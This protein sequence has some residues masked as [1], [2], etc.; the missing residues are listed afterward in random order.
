MDA[1][2]PPTEP[3]PRPL[4]FTTPSLFRAILVVGTVA[5]IAML[6]ARAA[7]PVM[8]FLE[9]SVVA[10]LT[11]PLLQ[12]MSRHMPSAVAV[13]VLT[14]A[15]IA[16]VGVLGAAAFSELHHEADRF[17]SSVPAAVRELQ[18]D[19]PFGGLM[20]DLKVAEQIDH[21][22]EELSHRFDLGADLPG[23]ATA[24]GGKVSTGFIIWVLTVMLV[25]TGPGMV[26]SSIRALP[27]RLPSTVGPALGPAYGN[28]VRYLGL[29]SLRALTI[30]MVV[31]VVST[32]LEIDMPVLLGSVAFIC[33]FLP[34]LGI[35][36]GAL[37]VA[38]LAIL[39]GPSESIAILVV[40]VVAQSIDSLVVQPR[41]HA[42]S[43]EVG[44][45]PTLVVTIVG[46]GLYGVTGLYLGMFAGA[47]V[48]ALLQQLDPDRGTSAVG[49][50]VG[51]D[52]SVRAGPDA[53]G[54]TAER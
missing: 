48:L 36:A 45:F 1:P 8:W 23:V 20:E 10:A 29:T 31:Y 34:Y 16:V 54:A 3:T 7:H 5:L 2:A 46:F 52:G 25:F 37:P 13:L 14:A 50:G 32:L 27:G 49:P 33:G 19:R 6:A 38:L 11:W 18:A 43:N 47:L 26:R 17:R 44:L 28:V 12:R 39:N 30:G 35:I 9:A 40:A 51:V 41:I 21:L 53:S 15:A 24:L 22:A 42:R 4:R